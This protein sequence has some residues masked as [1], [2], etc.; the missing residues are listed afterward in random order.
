MGVQM[1]TVTHGISS[2]ENDSDKKPYHQECDSYS[3]SQNYY[4]S[5]S[6]IESY[7]TDPDLLIKTYFSSSSE[8]R[9]KNRKYIIEQIE[10][11]KSFLAIFSYGVSG[12][13]RES[14]EGAINLLAET[15][16]VSFFK[17]ISLRSEGMYYSLLKKHPTHVAENFLEI[18]ITAIACAY[19]IDVK[20]RF[21]L[22]VNFIP[23]INSCMIKACMI[24]SLGLIADE[25]NIEAIKQEINK[26][27]SDED[28]YIS[29][30]AQEALQD[31]E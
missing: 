9:Y 16:N 3:F 24:D 18:L 30:Y 25:M 14:Y 13:Y 5:T 7:Q 31:I 17:E 6:S 21:D 2:I 22:L 4:S 29:D 27:I 10:D 1:A 20:D 28:S 26:F 19:K 23:K 11:V 8:E 15:S 12:E